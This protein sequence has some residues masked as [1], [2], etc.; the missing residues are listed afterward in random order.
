M[1]RTGAVKS[2]K[3]DSVIRIYLQHK[4]A[5]AP[6]W[7]TGRH[8]SSISEVGIKV[9]EKK[10]I[11]KLL[12]CS[13]KSRSRPGH[14][15]ASTRHW[16]TVSGVTGAGDIKAVV[17]DE[18]FSG[19]PLRSSRPMVSSLKTIVLS[20]AGCMVVISVFTWVE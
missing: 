12:G 9:N 7:A 10:S 2:L 14:H 19:R 4:R 17:M 13:G 11:L 8:E 6:D 3:E 15:R 1:L 20:D 18:K 5:E 16:F